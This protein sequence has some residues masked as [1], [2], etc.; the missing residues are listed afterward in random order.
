MSTEQKKS[1]REKV[2]TLKVVSDSYHSFYKLVGST[3]AA[4]DTELAAIE[5]DIR[6]FLYSYRLV[7]KT[8]PPKVRQ[9]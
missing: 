2:A 7:F 3:K 5:K 4:D 6:L 1:M 9:I 8:V